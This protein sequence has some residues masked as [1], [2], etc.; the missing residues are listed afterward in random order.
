MN[1]FEFRNWIRTL[2]VASVA[3]CATPVLAHVGG[4]SDTASFPTGFLHPLLGLDHLLA[5]LA[6]GLW[7]GRAG[8]KARWATPL[9]FVL[10]MGVGGWL[11]NLGVALPAREQ[12]IAA[13]VLVI[14]LLAAVAARVP[15]VAAGV[16]IA[17]FAVFH[18]HAHVAEAPA[19]GLAGYV[20]GFV[21]ATALLHAAGVV[22]GVAAIAGGRPIVA[23]SCGAGVA[24]TGAWLCVAAIV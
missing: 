7:A 8:G 4:A 16:L 20:T 24:V 17:V 3:C 14:G 5:M 2:A 9:T 11:A 22:L 23:R 6:V 1:G 13:S 19:G 15:A 21:A 18:G 10:A 12:G